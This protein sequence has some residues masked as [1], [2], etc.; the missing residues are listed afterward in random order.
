MTILEPFI[1]P[2]PRLEGFKKAINY[3]IS[4]SVAVC[5][6]ILASLI[7]CG[8]SVMSSNAHVR[9]MTFYV[10]FTFLMSTDRAVYPLEW[11]RVLEHY[12]PVETSHSDLI[13]IHEQRR[14]INIIII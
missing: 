2:T 6:F 5:E 1:V 13:S 8:F 12:S 10:V 9:F 14:K 3:R 7:T 11:I 4:P